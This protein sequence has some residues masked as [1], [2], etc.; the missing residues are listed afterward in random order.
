MIISQHNHGAVTV[1]K[2]EGPLVAQDADQF[3]D[4]VLKV[5]AGNLG[6]CAVDASAVPFVDSKGLEALVEANDQMAAGGQALKLCA[7]TE[8][9]R[10]TLELT[11]LA[12]QFEYFADTDSAVRSFL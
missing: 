1:I 4:A 3:K 12:S 11:Q 2:P 9:V 6:R 10:Q 7:V 5:L 8:T